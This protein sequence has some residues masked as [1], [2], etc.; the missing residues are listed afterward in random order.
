MFKMYFKRILNYTQEKR[1]ESVALPEFGGPFVR[2]ARQ[3]KNFCVNFLY[4]NIEEIN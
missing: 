3:R 2:T 1:A 4:Q